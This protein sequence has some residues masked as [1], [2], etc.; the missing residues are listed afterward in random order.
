MS[1]ATQ[2]L[3]VQTPSSMIA[4]YSMQTSLLPLHTLKIVEKL[5]WSFFWGDS[6]SHAKLPQPENI[7]AN[8]MIEEDWD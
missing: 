2:T 3:L 8:L 5:I 4:N 6:E 1:M 7:F